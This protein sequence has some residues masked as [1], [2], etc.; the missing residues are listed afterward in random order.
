MPF[1]LAHPAIVLQLDKTEKFSLT[2]LI[3]GCMVPDFEFFLQMREVENIG[4]HWYGILL[5]DIP[6][7]LLVCFIFHNLIKKSL[8]INLPAACQNRVAN[9]FSFKWNAYAFSNKIKILYSLLLGI[10]SHIVWDAF[11]HYDGFFVLLLPV[12]QSHINIIGNKIPAYF[13]LQ[14][15]SSLAGMWL[16]YLAIAKLP[17]TPSAGF[18]VKKNILYW[19]LFAIAFAVIVTS[20]ICIWPHYNS[21]WGLVMACMGGTI[22]AWILISF[23]FK[24]TPLKNHTHD[25]A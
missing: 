21:F 8:I 25:P 10:L 19:P 3:V 16:T 6:A 5:F 15:F 2:A 4:H 22:Y 11:T 13:F 9:L 14:I 1:T 23:I 18:K 24:N 17:Y 20:R 12:L 7:G